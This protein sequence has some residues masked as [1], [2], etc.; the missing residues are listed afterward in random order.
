MKT[1]VPGYT[2]Q[3]D[4]IGPTDWSEML[5]RFDDATIYQTW[6]YGSVR[7]GQDHLSHVVLKKD[8][9]IIAVAQARIIKIPI[10]GAGIAYITF[11]PLWRLRGRQKDLGSFQQLVRVLYNE[12]VLKQGLLLRILPNKIDDED[13]DMIHSVLQEEGLLWQQSIPS[14][15]TFLIDLSLSLEQLRKSL[16]QKWRNCLNRAEKSKLT[17]IEGTDGNLYERFSNIYKEM[18]ERKKFFEFVDVNKMRAVQKDLEDNLKM[19][20]MLCESETEPVS[21]V[22]CTAIGDTGIYLLGATND[23]GRTLQASYLVQW[24]VIE[25]LKGRGYRWYDLGG[26]DAEKNPG[27]YHFKAGL[28][29]KLGKEVDYLGQFDGCKNFVSSFLVKVGDQLRVASRKRK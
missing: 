7:W 14:Y 12:Y 8:G 18:H 10:V 26:I 16:D 29:G 21:A 13:V 4:N 6:S 9:E 22:V 2:V 11:G 1:L 25:W 20:I 17:I 15:R 3:I 19:T 27:T 24:R 23:K 28:S 5:P